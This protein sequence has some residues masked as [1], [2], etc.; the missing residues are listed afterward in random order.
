MKIPKEL[1]LPFFTYGLF[2]PGQI[3][4]RELRPL[5]EHYEENLVVKGKLLERDGLPI[6]KSGDGEVTGV[7][8][9]FK[10]ESE[11]DA[12]K[13]IIGIEPDKLYRWD[14]TDAIKGDQI[15]K[16]NL[17]VG[18]RPSRGSNS[19]EAVWDGR[20]EL[21]FLSALEVVRETLEQNRDFEWNLKPLFRLQMA[22]MLLWGA[23]ERFASF[24]YHLGD[25]ATMK[26]FKL[27]EDPVF[28]SALCEIVSE[29]RKVFRSD[30][31]ECDEKL[32]PNQ[33]EKALKY[34]YQV[35]SNIIHRGKAAVGDHDI[36]VKSLG[37]LSEIFRR[38]LAAEFE[39]EK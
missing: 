1:T 24:K 25:K 9:Y 20:Q 16:V 11:E 3:G 26:V 32:D 37:E 19:L 38:I 35:R 15:L 14:V 6:F 7:L 13:I 30:D 31:P 2:R 17:L 28:A 5:V 39:L 12:Y 27:A 36:L 8:I 22:Y 18:K 34:Y 4:Y 10:K 21:L 23:I 33:P 29:S